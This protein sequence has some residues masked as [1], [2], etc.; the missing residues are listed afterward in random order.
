MTAFAGF[1]DADFDAYLP[2][3]ALSHLYNRERLETKQKLLALGTLVGG[4]M[5]GSDRAPLACEASV[6]HPALWNHKRVDAQHLFFSRHA[7]ARQEIEGLIDKG[8]TL[9]S[10][11]DDPTPQRKHIFLAITIDPQG[12][13]IAL[14]LHT[15]ARIDHDNLERKC[16]EYFHRER[17]TAM[18]RAL[19]GEYRIG[20]V[21]G[22]LR[23]PGAVDDE[24][25]RALVGEFASS[26]S[27]LCVGRGYARSDPAPRGP[28][29]VD[30]AR[31]DLALLLPVFHFIAWTRDND[32][33]SV[34]ET[35]RQAAAERRV[36][37]LERGDRVRIVRGVLS[38]KAGTVQEIGEK[39]V[40]VL[41]GQMSVKVDGG[42]LTKF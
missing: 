40:K 16:A 2:R 41:V 39:G 21:G 19:P 38:G 8:R 35:L 7:Q 28:G 25:V 11:I 27:W 36:G 24:A 5:L 18:L 17:I 3:K 31:G 26:G 12:V 15:D 13:E 10:L 29:F 30:V 42:D 14:K 33:V 23:E 1:C 37:G 9:A 20:V 34:K 32:F 22:T 6:E 4:Q